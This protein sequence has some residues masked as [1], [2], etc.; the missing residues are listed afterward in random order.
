MERERRRDSRGRLRAVALLVVAATGP[1][2]V[3]CARHQVAASERPLPEVGV[4]EARKMDVPEK[5]VPNGTTQALEKVTIQAR[6]RGFLTGMHFIEGSMVKKGKLLFVIEEKPFEVQRDAAKA[7]LDSGLAALAKAKESKA[8]EVAAAQLALDTAQL[9]L[10]KVQEQRVTN[11]FARNAAARGDLDQA[12]A[13]R[14]K[15][16]AQVEADKANLDQSTADYE[17]NI[18]SAQ[19]DVDAAA[20]SLKE[21][22]INLGYCRMYAP[23]DGRIGEAKIK[24]GNLVGSALATGLTTELATIQQL[25]PMGVEIQVPSRYLDRV[26][27]MVRDGLPITI[28]RPGLDGEPDKPHAGKIN[29][30]DNKID[31]T[32]STFLTR[33]EVANPEGDLLPGEYVKA[34]VTVGVRKGVV[35]VPEEAV[36]ETQAGPT[37]YTVDSQGV[38]HVAPVKASIVSEGLRVIDSGLEPGQ[39]VIV[40]GIQEVRANLKVKT[41]PMAASPAPAS[42]NSSAGG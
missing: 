26:T 36:I 1:V 34:D 21:A 33:A 15:W 38:V 12:Q 42:A 30:I 14:E 24:L 35:V 28:A 25:D 32:T 40:E 23:I 2:C 11:L 16:A 19:A 20:A 6:V 27:R 3:G 18:R 4:V 41:R 29:F 8:K 9:S 13:D 37:V 5:A 31:P 22:D 17:T 39:S 7:K 10:A